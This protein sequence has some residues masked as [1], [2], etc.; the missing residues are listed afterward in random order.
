MLMKIYFAAHRIKFLSGGK[1]LFYLKETNHKCK[2]I[3]MGIS[4]QTVCI[5]L[6]MHFIGEFG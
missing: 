1:Y 4:L 5:D 2:S 3:K 6:F